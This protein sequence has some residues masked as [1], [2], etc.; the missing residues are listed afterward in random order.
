V[1]RSPCVMAPSWVNRERQVN[2]RTLL[3]GVAISFRGV[4]R[5]GR[6]R[7]GGT[8]LRNDTSHS[9]QRRG[10][11]HSGGLSAQRRNRIRGFCQGFGVEGIRPL[12]RAPAVC[13]G[14]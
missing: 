12:T 8:V 6:T 5:G 14:I 9:A 11:S 7:A 4:W 1:L 13:Q 10:W 2:S 3:E